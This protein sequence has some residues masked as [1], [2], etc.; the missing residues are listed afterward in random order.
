MWSDD[1]GGRVREVVYSGQVKE[2]ILKRTFL[3]V[4]KYVYEK[5]VVSEE[6][7]RKNLR[8]T[9]KTQSMSSLYQF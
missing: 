7:E 9:V 8:F 2:S 1:A 6:N 5:E 4:C 3:C